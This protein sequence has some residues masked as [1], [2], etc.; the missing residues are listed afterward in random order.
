MTDGGS[1]SSKV[2]I[3]DAQRSVPAHGPKIFCLRVHIEA[4]IELIGYSD[5]DDGL[6]GLCAMMIAQEHV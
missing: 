2:D 3:S 4:F 1:I 5:V 6:F